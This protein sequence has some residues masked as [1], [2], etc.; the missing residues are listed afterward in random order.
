ML[1]L[2]PSF[3]HKKGKKA[4]FQTGPYGR[5]A[6]I[7]AEATTK[8]RLVTLGALFL[9][10]ESSAPNTVPDFSQQLKLKGSLKRRVEANKVLLN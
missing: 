4:N 9:V 1:Q 2:Y 10:L 3:F 7:N 8:Q 6:W 5:K